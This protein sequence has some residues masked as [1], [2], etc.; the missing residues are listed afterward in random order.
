MFLFGQ[1]GMLLAQ[2]NVSD[3]EWKVVRQLKLP[4]QPKT[5]VH[6]L[7]GKLFF[8]LTQNNSVLVYNQ[9]GQLEG[10]IPV[11]KGVSDIDIAPRGEMLFLINEKKKTYTAITIDFIRK[12]N[13]SGSPYLGMEKAPVIITVFTDFQWPYCAKV[14]PLLEQVL[15]QNPDTVK[16]VLKNLTLTSIHK[17]AEKAALAALAA[18]EQGKF[19]QFH[20]EL[21]DSPEINDRVI[22]KIADELGLDQNRFQ[23][24]MGSKKIRNKLDRD[25]QDANKAKVTGTPT[26]F[27]NGRKVKNRGI[28]VIQAMIDQEL[29]RIQSGK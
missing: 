17:F 9:Q 23:K 28:A 7:D 16:I 6:S 15:E 5:M 8:I 24:D 12:I 10:T 3:L 1:P 26:I 2:K 18:G 21:F 20:D 25:L 22:N 4:Q 19:W 29:E 13:I 14:V 27:I 11:E